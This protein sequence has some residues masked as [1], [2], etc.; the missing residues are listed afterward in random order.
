MEYLI[1][2]KEYIYIQIELVLEK[3]TSLVLETSGG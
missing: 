3:A 1:C 2:Q